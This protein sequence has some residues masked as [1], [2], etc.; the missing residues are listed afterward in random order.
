MEIAERD[1]KI[2]LL[3]EAIRANKLFVIQKVKKLEKT[4]S[5]NTFLQTI[6]E[7]YRKYYD[8]MIEQKLKQKAQMKFL[9]EYLEKAIIDTGLSKSQVM[10]AKQE[11]NNI[12]DRLD[13]VRSELEML[14]DCNK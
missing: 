6:Y 2:I 11:Q 13:S 1:L 5:E 3:K 4:Q 8:Y 12:L 9:L 7:D 10:R 14:T